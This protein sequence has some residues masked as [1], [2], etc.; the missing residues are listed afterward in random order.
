MQS[1]V[2]FSMFCFITILLAPFDKAFAVRVFVSWEDTTNDETGFRIER[3]NA[4]GGSFAQ[5]AT[6]GANTTSYA[7]SSVTAGTTYCYRVR[8]YNSLGASPDS[9]EACVTIPTAGFTLTVNALGNGT[10]VAPGISCGTDCSETYA[11]GTVVGLTVSPLSGAI[12]LGWSGDPDCN[13]GQ[14]TMTTTKACTATFATSREA[15][16][17]LYRPSTRRWYL[18]RDGSGR[19]E[20]CTVDFCSEPFGLPGDRPVVGD[21]TNEGRDKIG[22]FAPATGLW[23]LDANGNGRFD[24]CSVDFCPSLFSSPGDIPVVG[25]W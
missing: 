6:V 11:S 18:D 8:G 21:W 2:L 10:I 1:S 12:F 15:K 16:I 9:N 19:I 20:N 7:D 14:L 23:E 13:D 22:V 3:K 4:A 17:G 24:G 25:N 5:V